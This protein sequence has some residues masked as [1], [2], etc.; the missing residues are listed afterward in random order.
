MKVFKNALKLLIIISIV[1][2]CI[3]AVHAED[4]NSTDVLFEEQDDVNNDTLIEQQPKS[5]TDLSYE[6]ND[7]EGQGDH[8]G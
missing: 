3:S 1:F 2:I 7:A 8:G 4:T 5:Y 6:V